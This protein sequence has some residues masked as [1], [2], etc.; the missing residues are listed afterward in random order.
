MHAERTAQQ[1]GIS[2]NMIRMSCGIEN[3]EDLIADFGPSARG[4]DVISRIS[5][6]VPQGQLK[7]A[8]EFAGDR[9]CI[10]MQV[11]VGYD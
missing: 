3:P 9:V 5:V 10:T 2:D 4:S 8:Q 1:Y 6:F 7:I 11:T